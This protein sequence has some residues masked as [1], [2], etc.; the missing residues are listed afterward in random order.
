MDIRATIKELKEL[1]AKRD[2]YASG[3]GE[4][5]WE[6]DQDRII[7]LAGAVVFYMESRGLV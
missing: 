5:F 3:E 4:T 6:H 1:L 2:S 7:D